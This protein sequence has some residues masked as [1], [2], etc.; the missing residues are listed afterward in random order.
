MN[1]PT[2]WGEAARVLAAGFAQRAAAHDRD[3]SFPHENFAEL[4]AAG[5]LALAAPRALSG[6]GA[7]IAQ[8]AEVVGAIGYGCPATALVLT[9]QYVQQRGMGRLGSP[10][11]EALARR[12]VREAVESVSLVN[13]LR[14]EHEP[15]GLPA[16]VAWQTP[17]GWRLSGRKIH[18]TGAPILRWYAVW[19]RT[20]EAV[21]RVGTFLVRADSP[22]VRVEP[23]WDY[24]G[25]RGS[26]SHNVVLHDVPTP[27]DHALGLQPTGAWPQADGAFQ[28]EMTLLLGAL[29]TGVARAARD[30]LL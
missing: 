24:L 3:G 1:A 12:L 11:P 30:W 2:G 18:A 19:A 27:P 22:G 7:S 13:A 9:M 10:W 6:Q 8:L 5:L 26:G 29:Y 21:P 17:E 25:L 4:H 23:T 15:G 16:T 14:V 28:T 20:D